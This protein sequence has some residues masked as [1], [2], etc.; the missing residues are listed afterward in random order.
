[1]PL[2]QVLDLHQRSGGDKEDAAKLLDALM[3]AIYVALPHLL[4]EQEDPS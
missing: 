1:M 4:Q 2:V 3:E